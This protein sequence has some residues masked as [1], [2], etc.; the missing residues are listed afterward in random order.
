MLSLT[1]LHDRKSISISPFFSTSPGDP[2]NHARLGPKVVDG[3]LK[4]SLNL[5]GV[6][7]HGDDVVAAGDLEH[8]GHELG[9]DG[10]ARLVLAVLCYGENESAPNPPNRASEGEEGELTMRE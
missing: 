1:Q 3:D 5:R 6:Q 4:E 8:V 7:V 10:R 2:P 9:G